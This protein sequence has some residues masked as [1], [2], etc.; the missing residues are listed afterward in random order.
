MSTV[1]IVLA[2]VAGIVVLFLLIAAISGKDM[3]IERSITINRPASE[4]FD[5]VSHIRNHEQFSVWHMLDPQMK[6]EYRG[7]DGQVGF[8]YAWDSANDKNVGA[9]EQE[10][11]KLVPGQRVEFHLRFLRPMQNKADATMIT[12]ATGDGQTTVQWIFTGT[13]K[14]PM[15][16]M[17][18]VFANMLGK[19]LAA[20][21]DNLKKVMER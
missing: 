4:V 12:T 14:F 13:M 10:I 7:T 9:G 19:Q 1:M 20:V 18:S 8:V 5:F 11:T 15:N 6:K 17:K 16:A 21:L 2:V 3:I